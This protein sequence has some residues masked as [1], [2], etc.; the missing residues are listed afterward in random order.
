VYLREGRRF[1]LSELPGA[2]THRPPGTDQSDSIRVRHGVAYTSCGCTMPPCAVCVESRM[3]ARYMAPFECENSGTVSKLTS[4]AVSTRHFI[5][6]LC[7]C[8]LWRSRQPGYSC[9]LMAA[10]LV[11]IS[12]PI[13]PYYV[14]A[15]ILHAS[16]HAA[17]G[18]DCLVC[19][20][21]PHLHVSPEPVT[22]SRGCS[23]IVTASL[24]GA[25]PAP[26]LG[27]RILRERC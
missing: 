25:A 12:S 3:R 8:A 5:C 15:V 22:I 7:F 10:H 6:A 2:A 1:A 24:F 23:N 19:V 14:C 18:R 26:A 11:G 17:L 20:V 13:P 21:T 16:A 9:M 27:L 4:H